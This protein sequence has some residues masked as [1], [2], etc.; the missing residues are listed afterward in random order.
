MAERG[1]RRQQTWGTPMSWREKEV[2]EAARAVSATTTGPIGR[3]DWLLRLAETILRQAVRDDGQLPRMVAQR[4][5]AALAGLDAERAYTAS[6]PPRV[7][8]R[9]TL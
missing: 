1:G 2:L 8:R 5:S 7:G 4:A 6:H 9:P 3:T